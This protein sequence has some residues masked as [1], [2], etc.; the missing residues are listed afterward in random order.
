[1]LQQHRSAELGPARP[2]QLRAIPQSERNGKIYIIVLATDKW[3][4]VQHVGT[5]HSNPIPS[6]ISSLLRRRPIDVRGVK[7]CDENVANE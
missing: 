1:M 4:S 7:A 3:T 6:A 5:A 2:G